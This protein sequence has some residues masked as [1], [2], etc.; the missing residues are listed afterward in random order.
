M[1][2][3]GYDPKFVSIAATSDNSFF[4]SICTTAHYYLLNKMQEWDPT[5]LE[6]KVEGITM[7]REIYELG[8]IDLAEHFH[9]VFNIY[10]IGQITYQDVERAAVEELNE[11]LLILLNQNVNGV[12]QALKEIQEKAR[13]H[14]QWVVV[15]L[16]DKVL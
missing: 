3:F 4:K 13:Q 14:Q 12:E 15:E 5:L 8:N 11:N 6:T 9:Q 2:L 7:I 1:F 10:D 16:I